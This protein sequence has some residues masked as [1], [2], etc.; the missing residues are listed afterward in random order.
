M[1]LTAEQIYHKLINE[2]K[3]FETKGQI[4]FYLGDIDIIVHQK[5]VVGN[6]M[7]EWLQGWLEYNKIEFAPSENSQMPPDFFL[8]PD[9]KTSNLL[10]VK[11]FNRE[12][13]PAFDIADF[14]MYAQE[15]IEKP[16]M[17][18][19]DYLIFG[20]VMTDDGYVIIKDL[21][22]K[23]VWEIS[24]RMEDYA[25][26]IQKKDGVIHKIRP[27]VWYSS[28]NIDY[29]VFQSLEH[30]ISA[31]DETVYREPKFRSTI[32]SNWLSTFQRNYKSKYGH[33]LD[34]PRWSDIKEIYNLKILRNIEKAK[35]QVYKYEMQEQNAI[36]RLE[37]HKAKLEIAKTQ[38]QID[39]ANEEIEKAVINLNKQRE[40][41][42]EARKKLNFIL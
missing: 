1:R 34:I 11:A 2:D 16:Y 35:E 27:A 22:L 41:L 29:S 4:K 24:R 21:W 32:A 37:K 19:V 40:K 26:N 23:K 36:E 39:K 6:I 7:Q 17:L 20:Y 28:S 38:K 25:I 12:K 30:F 18:Y 31:M 3:I 8:N 5:D 13:T 42:D 10:E 9:D 14:R 33:E 15:I